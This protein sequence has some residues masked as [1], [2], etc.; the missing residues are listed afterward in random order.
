MNSGF[1]KQLY[2]FNASIR[3]QL[4]RAGLF[5]LF[6][7]LFLWL[8]QPFGLQEY[9]NHYKHLHLL[10]YGV[11]TP[12]IMLGSHLIFTLFFPA[13]YQRSNWTTGKNILYVLWVFFAIGTGNWLYSLYLGFWDFSLHV[14]LIFQGMTLVIGVFPITFSTFIVYQSRLKIALNEARL[15]NQNL[16]PT[17]E[18]TVKQFILIPSQ[19]KSENLSVELDSLLYI[20]AM[21][22]YV[23]VGLVNKK[24]LLRN[25]LTA[26]EDALKDIPILKRCHRSFLVNLQNIASFSGNAQGL[27]L[28]LKSETAEDI[29]VS[30]TYVAQIK[31]AL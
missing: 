19:N 28:R 9:Q 1:L 29:P 21:E 2:P 24:V 13:W 17:E 16:H 10:G 14:F 18:S 15:L 5:G 7:F 6:I 23:E 31:A 20:K 25:S 30:R 4:I 26:T 8:F 12:A 22:N 27:S 11:I 3:K